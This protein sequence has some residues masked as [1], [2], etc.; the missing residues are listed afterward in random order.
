MQELQCVGSD[1]KGSQGKNKGMDMRE[2]RDVR[3]PFQGEWA[4]NYTSS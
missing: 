3:C 1:G 4:K 2:V